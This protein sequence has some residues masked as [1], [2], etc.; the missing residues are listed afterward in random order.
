MIEERPPESA[1]RKSGKAMRVS[2]PGVK[3][4]ATKERLDSGFR[5]LRT[6]LMRR[7]MTGAAGYGWAIER[8]VVDRELRELEEDFRSHPFPA[9]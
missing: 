5:L 2:K 6:I 9:S 7:Q 8:T 1:R 3:G 4:H